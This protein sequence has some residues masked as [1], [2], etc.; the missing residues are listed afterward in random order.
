MFL[1]DGRIPAAVLV[2]DE[3]VIRATEFV[4]MYIINCRDNST[5]YHNLSVFFSS[6]MISNVT[7]EK[8][9]QHISKRRYKLTYQLNTVLQQAALR[10]HGKSIPIIYIGVVNVLS[11]PSVHS[12]RPEHL[13]KCN[14]YP[15]IVLL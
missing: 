4:Q 1:K 14:I 13:S 2:I 5:T 6:N 12:L 9:Y 3:Y 8:Q 7:R 11:G 15:R 10:A